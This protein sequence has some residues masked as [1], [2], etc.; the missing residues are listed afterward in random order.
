[1]PILTGK[2]NMNKGSPLVPS[3]LILLFKCIVVLLVRPLA[4]LHVYMVPKSV[5]M[6]NQPNPHNFAHVLNH[7]DSGQDFD[8]SK[9]SDK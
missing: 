2:G 7:T 8:R 1:M 6:R 9:L 5:L 3:V 4:W